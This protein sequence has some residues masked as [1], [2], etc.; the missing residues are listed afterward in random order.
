MNGWIS[1]VPGAC[2]PT[3]PAGS[4]APPAPLTDGGEFWGRDEQVGLAD[5]QGRGD[6]ALSMPCAASPGTSR[7]RWVSWVSAPGLIGERSTG[8]ELA[9]LRRRFST[10]HDPIPQLPAAVRPE[11]VLR[12]DIYE[13]PR[14]ASYISG[15]VALPGDAAHAMT[16]T[17]G[18]GA[19]PAADRWEGKESGDPPPYRSWWRETR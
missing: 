8:G 11:T 3:G 19:D 7:S 12:N 2:V 10:W 18:Q 15:R 5:G 6:L 1:C 14:L 9:E 13:P 16:P 4:G 17:L